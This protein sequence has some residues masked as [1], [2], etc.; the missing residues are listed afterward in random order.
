MLKLIGAATLVALTICGTATL[1]AQRASP[2]SFDAD[3]LTFYKSGDGRVVSTKGHIYRGSDGQTRQ[4]TGFGAVITD[5]KAKSVTLLNFDSKQ[6]LV[7]DLRAVQDTPKPPHSGSSSAPIGHTTL[8]GHQVSKATG[9]TAKGVSS[10][11]L[12]RNPLTDEPAN[13]SF[14][15]L[16]E[17]TVTIDRPMLSAE[18]LL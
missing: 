14:I 13:P 17:K 3:V 11:C 2:P 5:L 16:N 9:V 6:A 12:I 10:R 18:P 8:E 15:C 1:G 4:E 7:F